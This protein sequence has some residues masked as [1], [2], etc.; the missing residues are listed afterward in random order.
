LGQEY[1]YTIK[2]IYLSTPIEECLKR[3]IGPGS[4]PENVI[5]RMNEQ[6]QELLIELDKHEN[7]TY[8]QFYR[9]NS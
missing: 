9:C 7:Y 5:Y 8:S 1:N 4:V 3:N 6:L 2:L